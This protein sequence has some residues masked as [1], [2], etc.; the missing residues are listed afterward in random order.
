M[1]I[2]EDNNF[3]NL[4]QKKFIDKT[5]LSNK[6]PYFLN[7]HAV[8]GDNNSFF[9]H[10]VIKRPEERKKDESLYNSNFADE[11]L[12]I[13]KSFIINNKINCEELLR[14]SVNLTY[15]TLNKKCPVHTDHQYPHKQL[16]I[17]LNN[18]K[19]KEAKTVLLNN[20]GK[21]I[22]KITPEQYKGVCFDSCP[23]YMIFPKQ[24]IRAVLVYTFR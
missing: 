5:I 9:C 12:E 16:L 22:H 13:F 6:F 20:V 10:T 24:D 18:C 2:I 14:C 1:K 21:I 23:H 19:D 15:Q 7:T 11:F 17:Y 3:L 4:K 8:R